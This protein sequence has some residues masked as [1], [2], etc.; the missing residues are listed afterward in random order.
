[1]EKLVKNFENSKGFTIIEIIIAI[2]I[3]S[4]AVIGIFSAFSIVV[5]LT[6]DTADRLTAT[7][8]AQEGME[9]VTNIRDTNW[10]N[11]D[12]C[13]ADPTSCGTSP[14]WVD[15]LNCT[16]G[17]GGDYKTAIPSAPFTGY[18]SYL[19]IDT[20]GFYSYQD[21]TDSKFKRK[22]TI[23]KVTD[24]D[25]KDDHIIKVKVE[26]SWDK[27]A[28]MLNSLISADTCNPSNCITTEETLY[29]WYNYIN[30]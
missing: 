4:V 9:I 3:L 5:I 18:T 22:I 7:Y 8:L 21:G 17:C 30:H 2:V 15:G 27:K 29:N 26:V 1:M 16:N 12:V 13:A 20:N 6:A 25:D 10:L 24:V 28:T 14:T 19:K 11:M 23:T